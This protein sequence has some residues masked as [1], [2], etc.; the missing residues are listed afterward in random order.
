MMCGHQPCAACLLLTSFVVCTFRGRVFMA[1]W[2]WCRSSRV[3]PCAPPR[4]SVSGVRRYFDK[5]AKRVHTFAV[6]PQSSAV[7][8]SCLKHETLEVG[9]AAHKLDGIGCGWVPGLLDCRLLD[10]ALS[11]SDIEARNMADRVGKLEGILVGM[12]G[13][14]VIAAAAKV[15]HMTRMVL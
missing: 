9:P 8:T 2:H 15:A 14:A 13:G 10:E 1:C 6:E 7:L 4:T 3:L 12:A 11:I 5:R